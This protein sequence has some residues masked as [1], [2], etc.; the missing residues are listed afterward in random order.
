MLKFDDQ[1][2]STPDL[3]RD[4]TDN[5]LTFKFNNMSS[6]HYNLRKFEKKLTFVTIGRPF[7]FIYDALG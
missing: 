6:I 1:N 2:R 3:Q 4:N 7:L 5:V